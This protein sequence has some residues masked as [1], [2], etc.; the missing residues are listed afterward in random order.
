MKGKTIAGSIVLLS[1]LVALVVYLYVL[2][3]GKIAFRPPVF[4]FDKNSVTTLSLS[5]AEEELI[6]AKGEQGWTV[7]DG[8]REGFFIPDHEINAIL[9]DL[10]ALS[11][12]AMWKGHI[13]TPQA[14]G[15]RNRQVLKVRLLFLNRAPETFWVEKPN[16]A[17]AGVNL[18]IDGQEEVF[19]VPSASVAFCFR[20]FSYYHDR[21]FA[22]PP[23]I[24]QTDSLTYITAED[25]V[26]TLFFRTEATWQVLRADTLRP[27]SLSFSKWWA[28]LDRF[29][30]PT[31]S[32]DFDEVQE[33][34]LPA[35]TLTFWS[36]GRPLLELKGF[37]RSYP[38]YPYFIHSSQRP[39]DYFACDSTGIFK[40][41]FIALDS[42]IQQSVK[43]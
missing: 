36:K 42:I 18:Q 33:A 39:G 3:S 7:S 13:S 23:H 27:D 16:T 5:S 40:Q 6:F 37:Y 26:T 29:T 10:N 30:A 31:P 14:P 15:D 21:T 41:I 22:F 25:S 20:P 43:L 38:P 28:Q 11:P 12:K 4:H 2:Y 34:R 9:K 17:D 19:S 35:N 1:A 8:K 32:Q 24:A